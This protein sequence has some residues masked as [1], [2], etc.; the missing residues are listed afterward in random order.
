MI[1]IGDDI[2]DND[3]FYFIIRNRGTGLLTINL[4]DI[5]IDYNNSQNIFTT[6]PTQTATTNIL[7]YD[8][9]S[10]SFFVYEISRGS[11]IFLIMIRNY[12]LLIIRKLEN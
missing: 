6:I 11:L 10:N 12:L 1:S 7:R 9:S 3:V 8:D 5:G 4:N 2:Q